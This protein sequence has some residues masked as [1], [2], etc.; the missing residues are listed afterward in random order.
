[1]EKRYNRILVATDGSVE[2]EFALKKGIALAKA[3]D[4]SLGICYIIDYN[5]YS[6][7]RLH[8]T[9]LLQASKEKGEEI[10]AAC[11]EEA[12]NAGLTDI[13]VF[14]ENGSP[15]TTIPKEIAKKFKADL[16]LCGA[17]GIGTF[18]RFIVGSVS[19]GIVRN[20]ECDVWVVR[21][22][23]DIEKYNNILIAVDDS[24]MSANAF[25]AGLAMAEE[26]EAK[27]VVTHVIHTPLVSSVE[28][29]RGNVIEIFK[30]NGRNLLE[31]YRELALKSNVPNVSFA[32]E[33][34]SPKMVIPKDAAEKYEADLIVSG[35][36]GVS[37]A[38]RLLLGSV[39]ESIVRRA[40]CDVLVVRNEH[41]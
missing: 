23:R 14:L 4:C 36:S 28:K 16:I 8:T 9:D 6:Q 31:I 37:S 22:K 25:R 5:H 20:A 21:N 24:E 29:T 11:R 27:A 26:E 38:E 40:E 30:K 1:M 18:E 39:G 41:I 13:T 7:A 19:A 12:E 15:R 32:L 34:G 35:A 10:I 33:Y 2:A 3:Y 17:S